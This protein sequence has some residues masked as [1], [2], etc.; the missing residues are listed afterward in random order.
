L[1]Q[2]DILSD[3]PVAIVVGNYLYL[4]GGEVYIDEG[5]A[6]VVYP[7]LLPLL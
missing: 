4:D 3:L 2:G 1:R 5:G 7:G 6:A